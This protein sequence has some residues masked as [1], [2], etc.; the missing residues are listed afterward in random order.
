MNLSILYSTLITF[1]TMLFFIGLPLILIICVST[2]SANFIETLHKA[3]LINKEGSILVKNILPKKIKN[4]LKE[5]NLKI[6]EYM[7]DDVCRQI[8]NF[9]LLWFFMLLFGLF[10]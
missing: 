4:E 8:K 3:H 6:D 7:I 2:K 1:F 5:N 10:T 9:I